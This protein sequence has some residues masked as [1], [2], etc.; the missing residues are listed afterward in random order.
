MA[1]SIGPVLCNLVR[2]DVP[3][4]GHE[5]SVRWHRIGLHGDGIRLDGYTGR[6]TQLVAVKFGVGVTV[7][8]WGDSLQ[9]LVG[10]IVT[11]VNDVG[12]ANTKMFIAQVG[13]LARR[14]A[15]F[16]GR[17]TTRGEVEILAVAL[18]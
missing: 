13:P 4:G 14:E 6:E 2:G 16:P 11:I 17:Y 8:A 9:A 12:Q 15:Y 1:G 3:A 18:P 10:S 5:A 7:N